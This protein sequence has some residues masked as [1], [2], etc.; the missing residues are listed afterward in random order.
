MKRLDLAR[1]GMNLAVALDQLAY[2]VVTLGDGMPDE[3]AS[4]AAW[5][6]EQKGK[7]SGKVFRPVIDAV[8]R[9]LFR[10][11]NHCRDSFMSEVRREHQP[12]E[13]RDYDH[14]GDPQLP[15]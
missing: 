12:L 6:L 3:T 4:S 15:R 10:Q 14:T 9:A 1:R 13:V 5:R 2:V 11:E 8:F 7:L